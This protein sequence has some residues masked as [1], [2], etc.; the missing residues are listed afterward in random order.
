MEWLNYHHLLYFWMVAKKGTRLSGK[1]IRGR[2]DLA[3]IEVTRRGH[4]RELH[5]TMGLPLFLKKVHQCRFGID[6]NEFLAKSAIE[7]V[8]IA[9]LGIFAALAIAQDAILEGVRFELFLPIYFI[10]LE[11]VVPIS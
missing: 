3:N 7:Q 2:E 11:R 6:A 5:V 4:G 10:H 9:R 8:D 1:K